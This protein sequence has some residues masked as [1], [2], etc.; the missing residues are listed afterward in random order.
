MSAPPERI[1]ADERML[2]QDL[3][4]AGEVM[5]LSFVVLLGVQR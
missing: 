1:R 3:R 5:V 4:R 2:P